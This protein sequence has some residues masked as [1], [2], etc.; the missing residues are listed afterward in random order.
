MVSFDSFQVN[1]HGDY[2]AQL[3]TSREIVGPMDFELELEVR[4]YRNGKP[5]RDS[6]F[7]NL[8]IKLLSIVSSNTQKSLV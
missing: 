4:I 7:Y 5:E 6:L 8:F 1:H 2:V 3:M